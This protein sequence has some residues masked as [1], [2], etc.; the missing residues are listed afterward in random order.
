MLNGMGGNRSNEN[1][2]DQLQLHGLLDGN[3]SRNGFNDKSRE[4][5]IG[6]ALWGCSDSHDSGIGHSPPYDSSHSLSG[7]TANGS[8]VG[9]AIWNELGKVLGSLDSSPGADTCSSNGSSVSNYHNS[10]NHHLHSSVQHNHH[11]NQTQHQFNN[12]SSVAIS[13]QSPTTP[14]SASIDLGIPA[15]NGGFINNSNTTMTN[16]CGISNNSGMMNGVSS[17]SNDHHIN[18]GQFHTSSVST[19]MGSNTSLAQSFSMT[20]LT[21]SLASLSASLNT[22]TD[23]N[24]NDDI[25]ACLRRNGSPDVEISSEKLHSAFSSALHQDSKPI[26]GLGQRDFLSFANH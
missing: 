20:G 1:S 4:I 17:S 19:T 18:N 5:S 7:L 8:G 14:R 3:S 10:I 22:L 13:K 11:N 24:S 2:L 12:S 26:G 9:G 15:S 23:N 21:T 6:S 25:L 16:G